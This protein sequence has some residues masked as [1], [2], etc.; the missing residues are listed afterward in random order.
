MPPKSIEEQVRLASEE[1]EEQF[2]YENPFV[3]LGEAS[4][5]SLQ[6]I[7]KAATSSVPAP[8]S[9][10]SKPPSMLP[11]E[12]SSEDEDDDEEQA[13]PLPKVETGS[14][15]PKPG[16]GA[17]DVVSKTSRSN[18]KSSSKAISPRAEKQ[19]SK[20]Q[21]SADEIGT[22][23]VHKPKSATSKGATGSGDRSAVSSEAKS[24]SP[25]ARR[26]SDLSPFTLT[27]PRMQG[28]VPQPGSSSS[29]VRI[30]G[31][32][33]PPASDAA[34]IAGRREDDE[35]PLDDNLGDPEDLMESL[36]S[37]TKSAVTGK[38]PAKVDAAAV[39]KR[40]LSVLSATSAKGMETVVASSHEIRIETL[41]RM[42]ADLTDQNTALLEQNSVLAEKT[43]ALIKEVA[44]LRHDM[45]NEI[46]E[47]LRRVGGPTPVVT[48]T[49]P[50][51]VLTTEAT[52]LPANVVGSSSSAIPAASPTD[53][54]IPNLTG[55]ALKRF[56]RRQRQQS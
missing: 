42:V 44:R 43:D 38:K 11:E 23:V 3:N 9:S 8:I 37:K 54:S 47:K 50:S 30:G 28:M 24:P 22:T 53:S 51:P 10:Q 27:K 55:E 2:D 52:A 12:T 14:S 5:V 6:D 20:G 17:S 46:N 32:A 19:S 13:L 33:S 25:P 49:T 16:P 31:V 56:L 18:V 26:S 34:S 39:H 45:I 15:K 36:A 21:K 35:D 1:F 40:G 4:A 41:E 29:G 48:L 7:E